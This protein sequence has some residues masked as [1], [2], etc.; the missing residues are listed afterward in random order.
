MRLIEAISK[1]ELEHFIHSSR[2]LL[3]AYL[4]DDNKRCEFINCLIKELIESANIDFDHG[5]H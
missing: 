3:D 5:M 4:T 2:N 1:R